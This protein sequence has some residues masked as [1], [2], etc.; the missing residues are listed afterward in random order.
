[1]GKRTSV[2]LPDELAALTAASPLSLPDLIA[3]GL[4]CPGHTAPAPAPAPPRE[5]GM[6]LG[7]QCRHPPARVM[8]G[9]CGACGCNVAR[10]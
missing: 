9:L 6:V 7:E 10:K 8:K 3:R 5:R 2:Y 4:A 1:V